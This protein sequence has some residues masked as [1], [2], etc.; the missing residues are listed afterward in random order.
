MA[1]TR[2]RACTSSAAGDRN[3]VAMTQLCHQHFCPE[4]ALALGAH[5]LP[6]HALHLGALAWDH[7]KASRHSAGHAVHL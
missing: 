5:P 2:C 1:S 6:Q 3:V 7:K 4:R